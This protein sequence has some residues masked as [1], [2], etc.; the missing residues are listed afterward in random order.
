MA[1]FPT[2]VN[3]QQARQL[4]QD[5]PRAWNSVAAFLALPA[6]QQS[7]TAA[8]RPWLTVHSQRF[9]AAFTVVMGST[10]YQRGVSCKRRSYFPYY[11][12]ALWTL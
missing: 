2:G 10:R 6:L 4:L 5:R 8:A 1:L 7:D 3:L 12:A 11:P 9:V